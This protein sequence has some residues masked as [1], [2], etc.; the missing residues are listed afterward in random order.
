M[1]RLPAVAVLLLMLA[2]A[3][4]FGSDE[5]GDYRTVS[6]DG[7][8]YGDTLAF[9]PL[10]CD[11]GARGD[12]VVVVRHGNGYIY[13]NI[14]LEMTRQA[15]DTVTVT[16]TFNIALADPMGR[17]YGTGLG[18]SYQRADTVL[19]NIIAPDSVPIKIRHIMRQDT[20]EDIE[21]IGIVFVSNGK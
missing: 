15:C 9:G 6:A 7:W 17:W 16:D 12:L 20:L 19:K 1:K 18:L 3:C 13:S 8:L 2:A 10:D 4:G 14:W 11:S 21:Q 5:S